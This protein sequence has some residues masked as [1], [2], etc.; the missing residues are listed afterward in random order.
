MRQEPE[1][2]T[3]ATAAGAPRP[4][5][6][7]VDD[8]PSI[9]HLLELTLREGGFDVTTAAGGIQAVELYR[10]WP[11]AFSLVLLDVQM[12]DRDGPRTL[13]VLRALDPRVCC[14]FMTGYTGDYTAEQLLALGAAHVFDKPFHCLS[15]LA[16]KLRQVLRDARG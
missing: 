16:G 11:G 3:A 14:C 5:V 6:L 1:Q 13:A 9:L 4:H 7:V 12:P 8:E 15:E 10:R 2:S